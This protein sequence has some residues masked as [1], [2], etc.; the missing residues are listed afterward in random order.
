MSPSNRFMAKNERIIAQD[1]AEIKNAIQ[2][3]DSTRIL[4]LCE[5]LAKE[6]KKYPVKLDVVNR[7]EAV[8]DYS[9]TSSSSESTEEKFQEIDE[10]IDIPISSR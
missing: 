10:L 9:D 2:T 8:S 6:I 4:E 5:I 3:H 1:L 7:L